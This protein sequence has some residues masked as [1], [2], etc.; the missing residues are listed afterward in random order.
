METPNLHKP[1]NACITKTKMFR[2]RDS[3]FCRS[4]QTRHLSVLPSI[5]LLLSQMPIELHEWWIS[6]SVVEPHST[7]PSPSQIAR[8]K[9]LPFSE[10]VACHDWPK[11]ALRVWIRPVRLGST[12]NSTGVDGSTLRRARW[13]LHLLL[14][15]LLLSKVR[16][17]IRCVP[18]T[19]SR[20]RC[21]YFGFS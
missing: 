20:I 17:K 4:A 21:Y 14:G 18:T 13:H 11:S 10:I 5:K 16:K 1:K 9:S 3:V 7:F 12:R 2:H 8:R 19:R 6:W 15:L